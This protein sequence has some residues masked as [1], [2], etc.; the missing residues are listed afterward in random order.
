LREAHAYFLPSGYPELHLK[1]ISENIAMRGAIQA[2]F[3]S[4]KPILAEC[5]GMMAL[6]ESING[7][8]TFGLLADIAKLNHAYKA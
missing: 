5:G 6:S 7:T 4:G 2:A 1:E 3:N 8:P